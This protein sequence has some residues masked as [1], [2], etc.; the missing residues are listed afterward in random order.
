MSGSCRLFYRHTSL[1]EMPK[2][3]DKSKIKEFEHVLVSLNSFTV[4]LFKRQGF[5]RKYAQH[6]TRI[7]QKKKGLKL[8]TSN[9]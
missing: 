5:C 8:A 9:P 2:F 6:M 7:R 1:G 3:Q 4:T